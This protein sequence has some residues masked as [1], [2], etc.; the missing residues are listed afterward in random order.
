MKVICIKEF[1]PHQSIVRAE[2]YPEVGNIYTVATTIERWGDT[3]F[4]LS[5]LDPSDAFIS[6]CFALISNI[7]ETELINERQL[8][9][10]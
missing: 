2:K 3:F 8:T 4:V 6:K 1:P 7:D 9:N 5:E 10:A